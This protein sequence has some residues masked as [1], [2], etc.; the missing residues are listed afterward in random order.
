VCSLGCGAYTYVVVSGEQRGTIWTCSDTL[1]WE[2]DQ[3]VPSWTPG[4]DAVP[5]EY[6]QH[7]F[8]TWYESWLDWAI[9][10]P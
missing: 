8:L 9:R 4:L 1:I 5:G 10:H 6:R 7:N 2:T 3:V